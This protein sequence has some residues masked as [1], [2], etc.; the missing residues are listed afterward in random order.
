M[1]MKDS[2]LREMAK[3]RVDFK[4]HLMGYFVINVFLFLL[5][6]W[7]SPEHLW[8]QWPAA[9]WGF[10]VVVHGVQ[11]YFLNEAGMEEAEFKKLKAS[12]KK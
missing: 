10:F 7:F 4:K 2:E 6:M 3:K 8:F 12:Q 11:A 5:N 1:A 9:L